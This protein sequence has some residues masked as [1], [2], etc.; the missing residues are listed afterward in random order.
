MAAALGVYIR[1]LLVAVVLGSM[2]LVVVSAIAWQRLRMMG[3]M[4]EMELGYG[5]PIVA[6]IQSRTFE[7][8]SSYSSPLGLRLAIRI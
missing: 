7:A 1:G 5:I 6:T 8:A 3:G 2:C 4:K